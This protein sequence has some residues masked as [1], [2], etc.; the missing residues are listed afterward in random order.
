MSFPAPRISALFLESLDSNPKP[1]TLNPLCE[2][3][4]RL[5][6]GRPILGVEGY[7]P[8]GYSQNSESFLGIGY[9]T[10]LGP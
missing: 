6:P 1:Q 5:G 7:K 4:V 9:V 2:G 3:M 10:G 8:I